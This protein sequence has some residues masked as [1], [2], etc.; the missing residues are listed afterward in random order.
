MTALRRRTV[1]VVGTNGKGTVAWKV[2]EALAR[3]GASGLIKDGGGERSRQRM[4]DDALERFVAEAEAPALDAVDVDDDGDDDDDTQTP[5]KRNSIGLY[6]SPH[7]ASLRERIALW[8]FASPQPDAISESEFVREALLIA[9]IAERD[10]LSFFEATTALAL[11]RFARSDVAAAVVEAGMGGE[12]DATNVLLAP[13]VVVSQAWRRT[14]SS[15]LAPRSKTC[16]AT[17]LARSS[18]ART[19]LLARAFPPTSPTPRRIS[20]T[21]AAPR[22]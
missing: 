6:T 14:T 5:P 9:A 15:N 21:C 18:A 19:S 4:G 2:A 11:R 8:R 22:A 7:I 20:H 3:A 12:G 10:G 1:H 16:A 13:R 17:R